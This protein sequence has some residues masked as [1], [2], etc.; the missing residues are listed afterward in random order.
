MEQLSKQLQENIRKMSTLRLQ[1]KL[2]SSGM[3]E[4]V[5]EGMDRQQLMETWARYVA[6]GKDEVSV[7]GTGV[8]GT[9]VAQDPQIERERLMWEREKFERELEFRRTMEEERKNFEVSKWQ[10]ERD[11]AEEMLKRK[12]E[13]L[14][15]EREN[16]KIQQLKEVDEASR[17]KKYADAL[18]GAIPK[19]TNDPIEVVAFFRNVERLFIDFKVPVDLQSALLRPFLTD[20]SKALIAK[21][22]PEKSSR[23]RDIK[24]AILKEYK[25]SAPMYRDKFNELNKTDEQ[26]YVMY[27]SS[28]FSLVSGYTEAR[29]VTS[30]DEMKDLLVSDRL[31]TTLKPSILRHVLSVEAKSER[32]WLSPYELADLAD[33]F[34]ANHTDSAMPKSGSLGLVGPSVKQK[35]AVTKPQVDGKVFSSPPQARQQQFS[36]AQTSS[37]SCWH[38]G[39]PH[40]RK[41]CPKRTST[42]GAMSSKP[43]INRRV[44]VG[45]TKSTIHHDNFTVSKSVMEDDEIGDF[46]PSSIEDSGISV[47]LPCVEPI[48]QHD[49]VNTYDVADTLCVKFCLP[50]VNVDVCNPHS[51][52]KHESLVVRGLEDSG[53]EI[54]VINSTVVQ[55]L[56]S[57]GHLETI[58]TVQLSG[59]CGI[60]VTCPLLK[61][62]IRL[63]TDNGDGSMSNVNSPATIVTCAVLDGATDELILPSAI[64]DHLRNSQPVEMFTEPQCDN[65][66]T[67]NVITR[68][69]FSTVTAN[70]SDKHVQSASDDV[71]ADQVYDRSDND[72]DDYG[73]KHAIINDLASENNVD[74]INV[75]SEEY[76]ENDV[77]DNDHVVNGGH[78]DLDDLQNLTSRHQLIDEQKQD[79]SLHH[80]WTLLERGKGN[81]ELQDGVLVRRDN[82]SS[83][84]IT[85]LVVPSCKR[86]QILEFGHDLAGHMSP[87]K[88]SQRI[89]M[90]FWWPTLKRDVMTHVQCCK[91][92][93]LVARKTVWDRT[94]I[95]ATV[96]YEAPFLHWHMDVLGPISSEK[97]QYPYCLLLIDSFSR[98][99]AG[100]AIKTP[101]AKNI[102]DCLVSLWTFL[103]VP[104]Y[105][106]L[107]NATCNVAALTRQMLKYFGVT[108]RFITPHHS[109]GNA[110]AERLIGTTK[111]LIAK[112]AADH[113]KSWHKH[114]PFVMWALRE[115]PSDLTGLSPWMLVMGSLPRGPLSV[116]RDSWTGECELTPGLGKSPTEYLRELHSHLEIAKQY[117]ELHSKQMQQVY[118]R[119]YNQR[120]KNKYFDVGDSVL[121]LQPNSTTSRMFAT[122]KGPAQIVE[123]LSPHSYLVELDGTRYRLHANQLRRFFTKVDFVHIDSIGFGEMEGSSVVEPS[124]DLDVSERCVDQEA[125]VATCAII[126]D[127]HRDFGDIQACR[128]RNDVSSGDMSLPSERIDPTSLSHLTEIEKQQL[129]V[130]LDKYA[131]VFCD[132]PG[133]YTGVQHCIPVSPDFKPKRLKEY[134][135]PEKIKSEVMRQIENLLEQGII[136]R[137]SS[138]M[139]SPLVCILKGPCGRDGIRLAVDFRYLNKHSIADAFP[140]GDI[141]D[142]IQ[143]IGNA[144]YLTVCDASQGYWQTLVAPSDRWKT[145]FICDDQ[146]YEWTRTPFGLKSSGQTFCRAVQ[147]ILGP[148]RDI[149]ASFVDD[150]V[151]YSNEF[152]QHLLDLDQF[153][154]VVRMSGMTLKLRKC[155]F[156]VPEVKFCGQIVGSGIRRPDPEKTAVVK[157]LQIPKTKRQV[158]QLL[159]F[160]SY[161]RECIPNFAEIA[162]PLTDL[163]KRNKSDKIIWGLSEQSA[164]VQL[165][166]ALCVVTEKPLFIIDPTK[167]FRLHVDASDHTVA[168]ALTQMNENGVEC[169]IAFFSWKLSD[170]QKNWAT[171]EKEA[172]AALKTLHRVKQWVFGCSVTILSD[173]NPLVYLTQSA[174]KSAKL[175]RWALAFQEFDVHFEYRA[176]Q[177]HVVPDVLTRLCTD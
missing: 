118:V 12:D 45:Q 174:P 114:L 161:F 98:F 1:S 99:P 122:W 54:A 121:V 128:T 37:L 70:V 155:K 157:A 117:A 18:R 72:C 144:R 110:P 176:G 100:F 38:C 140:I 10:F 164:F 89:R 145:G 39:G 71:K 7:G 22:S 82:I 160:F 62:L 56:Q 33:D 152:Q 172:Y 115:V 27:V 41:N 138:P 40:L 2:L 43:T 127:E 32:G 156:A 88:T 93:Q 91:N 66:H 17:L 166:D 137:S 159:G 42:G 53:A 147:Q 113:P 134:K 109:E 20:R 3:D 79:P 153:L 44:I 21:L 148:I 104:R 175:L 143:R 61:V 173:H 5:V 69:G 80:C 35:L 11:R 124:E 107:D 36:G 31:K 9:A 162:R 139:A 131:D 169:P 154:S 30:L 68:S 51:L 150:M 130:V 8:T 55:Q 132:E 78:V 170:S 106:S 123:K 103:G 151:V 83:H 146:L 158:R 29:K 4:T 168:G 81:F 63:R 57:F 101:T 136:Q 92:C 77:I 48:A 67:V 76:T 125:R 97:M 34:I 25:I 86:S 15:I 13:R 85:Q 108:P 111:R 16:L 28:L 120:S 47:D 165:K 73:D 26:T 46:P 49:T 58:G 59:I 24:D 52:D 84:E 102:C 23:Y 119:R 105:L 163:T 90:N 94:P 19:Q 142:I 75:S 74:Q 116:L 112:V 60:S 87:K 64:V 126:H 141:H 14:L 6:E 65:N 177:T 167:D 171:I 96:R 129:F 149:A 135:I 50:Y 133:L 95:Q